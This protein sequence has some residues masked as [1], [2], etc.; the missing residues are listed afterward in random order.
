[1]ASRAWPR[2]SGIGSAAVSRSRADP[3]TPVRTSGDP[4]LAEAYYSLP[5]Y[6]CSARMRPR[7]VSLTIWSVAVARI[8]ALIARVRVVSLTG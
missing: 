2:S 7:T 6:R 1:M 5:G 8:M 4:A 3:A